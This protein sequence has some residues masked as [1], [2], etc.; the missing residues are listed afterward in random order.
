MNAAT[1]QV[2]WSYATGVS[3]NAGATLV[4]GTVYWGSG[5][6]NLGLGTGGNQTFYGFSVGGN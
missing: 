5:Y 4:Q 3:V 1:G 2:L 6:S